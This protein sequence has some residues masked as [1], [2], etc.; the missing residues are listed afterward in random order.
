MKPVRLY[1]QFLEQTSEA[2][3]GTLADFKYDLE[4]V[5]GNM[6]LNPV[7]IKKV[8]KKG[9]GYEV[10][11]SS[12]MSSKET[13]EAIAKEIGAELTSFEKGSINVGVFES[14]NE[15]AFNIWKT[16]EGVPMNNIS[17]R[18][19][20]GD[21]KKIIKAKNTIEGKDGTI[22][23]DLDGNIVFFENPEL[24][25]EVA[26]ELGGT[27]TSR[28]E[29]KDGL[30]SA[31]SSR[32]GNMIV[33][34]SVTESIKIKDIKVGTILNF[35]DGEVWRVTKI[36]GPTSNPRS[37][38]AKPHDENTKKSN[39]SIEIEMKP[40]FLE[41]ELE[42]INE[43]TTSWSKMMK[44][45]RASE[46]GP[47]SLVAIENKKVV[48]Q[49]IDIRVA[50]MLPAHFEAMR[51]EYPKAKI[52][53]EDGTGQVV[54][55]E[56]NVNEAIFSAKDFSKILV[57]YKVDQKAKEL[58][59]VDVNKFLSAKKD[60]NSTEAP[61]R[62]QGMF[63]M[64]LEDDWKKEFGDLPKVGDILPFKNERAL[65]SIQVNEAK[66]FSREEMMDF[67]QTKYKIKT[68]RTSEEFD[69]EIGGIWIAG[70]NEESLSNGRIF[71]Y[72]NNSSKYQGGVL[73]NVVDAVGKK[74]W[75]FSWN[76]PGTIMMWPKN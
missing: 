45:V 24:G 7:V 5:V 68:V 38:L 63:G 44:G 17:S 30:T 1:E 22:L 4:L 11:M 23:T 59:V 8:S 40:D 26:A 39:T 15:G 41:K 31:A 16:R 37:F 73:K 71:Y 52:H 61:E 9:K 54:W 32:G 47:W 34:E 72:Y 14:V 27:V 36:M 51:K 2:Y 58:Y 49:K 48:G 18:K 3:D 69:G 60:P 62:F 29:T 20:T 28:I 64:M 67:M 43:A 6:G 33:F 13:W 53:I 56:S 66:D 50:D 75:Y 57:V 10:R 25:K 65:E 12:Y 35:K 70:D 55:N 76:D 19:I 74:G 46:T 42:S 21:I